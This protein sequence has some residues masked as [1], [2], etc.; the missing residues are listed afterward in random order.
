[1]TK[2]SVTAKAEKRVA[3]NG[4]G[5]SYKFTK[6]GVAVVSSGDFV[7]SQKVQ[8][9]IQ[10]FRALSKGKTGNSSS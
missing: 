6:S 8:D 7:R 9:G 5:G 1:M 3:S 10:Q 4:A 2:K